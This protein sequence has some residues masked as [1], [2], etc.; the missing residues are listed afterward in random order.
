MTEEN[1]RTSS[2]APAA[3]ILSWNSDESGRTLAVSF[4]TQ[5]ERIYDN[6]LIQPCRAVG[7]RIVGS[8]DCNASARRGRYSLSNFIISVQILSDVT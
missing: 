4:K 2:T 3:A 7:A 1:S 8:P 5:N 6:V